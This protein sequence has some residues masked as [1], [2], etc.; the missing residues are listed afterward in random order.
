MWEREDESRGAMGLYPDIF[1]FLSYLWYAIE[2][3]ITLLALGVLIA[4]ELWVGA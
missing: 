2:L 1:F 4:L 3:W